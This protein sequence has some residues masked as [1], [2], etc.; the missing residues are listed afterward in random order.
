MIKFILLLSLFLFIGCSLSPTNNQ[1]RSNIIASITD[2]NGKVLAYKDSAGK[3]HYTYG[4]Y[5]AHTI[6][7][8]THK[9]SGVGLEKKYVDYLKD[10]NT[11]TTT[12]DLNLLKS[13]SNLFDEYSGSFVIMNAD[14]GAV[15]AANSFPNYDAN[16]FIN[17]LSRKKYEALLNDKRKPFVNKV[18]NNLYKPSFLIEPVVALSLLE[19]GIDKNTKEYCHHDLKLGTHNFSTSFQNVNEKVNLQTA[20]EQNCNYYFYTNS[21]KVGNE[22][23]VEIFRRFGFG[24]ATGVDLANEFNGL[25]GDKEWK[26][27]RYHKPWYTGNTIGNAV[28]Q[29]YILVTPMQVTRYMAALVTGKLV[30]PYFVKHDKV[31]VS[32]L[33]FSQDFLLYIQKAMYNSFNTKNGQNKILAP[34]DIKIAGI[35]SGSKQYISFYIPNAKKQYIIT[36]FLKDHK[37]T[38][39]LLESMIKILQNNEY[40]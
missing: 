18:I 16:I 2:K 31:K 5:T 22:K 15:V 35:A 11:L 34:N 6:G 4:K 26:D 21:L 23:I 32:T 27:K 13:L 14:T 33:P 17:G 24:K 25:V 30:T 19:N 12:L 1:N 20:L 29:G 7:Y 3:Q 37:I 40:I 9:G 36:L 28:G 10:G 39:K 38:Q 8:I